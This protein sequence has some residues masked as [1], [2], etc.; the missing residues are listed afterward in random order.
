LLAAA[1]AAAVATITATATATAAAAPS[2]DY[3]RCELMK[4]GRDGTRDTAK[5][6]DR[7]RFNFS[8]RF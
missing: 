7:D 3:C 2:F 5:I 1:A 8:R 4:R 6:H